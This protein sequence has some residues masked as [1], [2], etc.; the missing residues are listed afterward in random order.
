MTV[1]LVWEYDD[2]IEPEKTLV[3][4]YSTFEAATKAQKRL[5][6]G[7]P[8]YLYAVEPMEVKDG[9]L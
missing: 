5:R 7:M 4:I 2:G 9:S 8:Q 3:A 1:Y 6:D